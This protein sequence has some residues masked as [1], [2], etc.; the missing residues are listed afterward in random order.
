MSVRVEL[1]F[2][3]EEHKYTDQFGNVY[4]SATTKLKEFETPFDKELN[5][6][7]CA[8]KG[9]VGLGRYVGMNENQIEQFWKDTT[10]NSLD[11][12]NKTHNQLEENIK[13]S[14]G[15]YKTEKA[16][17]ID[18]GKRLKLLTVDDIMDNHSFGELDIETFIKTDIAKL[19]PDFAEI[20]I[21]YSKQGY[22]MY[23]ELGVYYFEALLSGLI[24]LP[25]IN[26][27]TKSIIVIDYKTNKHP[28]MFQSGYYRKNSDGTYSD[29]FISTRKRFKAPL[30]HL[31]ECV[32][33]KYSLQVSYYARLL[34]LKTGFKTKA[35]KIF[36]IKPKTNEYRDVIEPVVT[37]TFWY[38]L[39]YYKK[40]IDKVIELHESKIKNTIKRQHS[41]G[42]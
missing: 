3:E 28:M 32:G 27:E 2:N 11:R 19:Y 17:Y 26:F 10:N 25:L 1:Y 18:N 41:L 15:Y 24:D 20:I 35:I 16:V 38:P 4:T 36:H 33:L 9:R 23:P 14:N 8:E 39:V 7:K 22:R 34:E 31:P 40:E 30:G 6:R 13:L 21:D 12:G 42:L 29:D 37:E 5:L